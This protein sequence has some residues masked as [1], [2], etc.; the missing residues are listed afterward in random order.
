MGGQW[1][2]SVDGGINDVTG[3]RCREAGAD[4]LV[5]GSWLMKATD[6]AAQTA[7]LRG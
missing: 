5:S 6:R 2:I 4:V 3:A 1:L 7:L